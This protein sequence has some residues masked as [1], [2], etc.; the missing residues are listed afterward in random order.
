MAKSS[1]TINASIEAKTRGVIDE[2]ATLLGKTRTESMIDSTRAQ[3]IDTLPAQ[4]HFT[5]DPD[6][7]DAFVQALDNPPSPG[8]KLKALLRRVPARNSEYGRL[9][10]HR[11]HPP[12]LRKR[13]TSQFPGAGLGLPGCSHGE[14]TDA[15]KRWL[16]RLRAAH[17]A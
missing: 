11:E 2:A 13:V 4:H 14:V 16:H 17:P 6:H 15:G 10:R 1:G 3:A 8:P 7:Y 5:L 9:A 12:Q